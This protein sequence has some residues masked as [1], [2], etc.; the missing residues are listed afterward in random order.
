MPA[1]SSAFNV[2]AVEELFG[3]TTALPD[4]RIRITLADGRAFVVDGQRLVQQD[5]GT[6]LIAIN[7]S[8]RAQLSASQSRD[9][10]DAPARKRHV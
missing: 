9:L 10:D 3:H 8:D 1:R 6:Y 2:R 4:E 5:D 7:D